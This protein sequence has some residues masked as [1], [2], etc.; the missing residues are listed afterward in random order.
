MRENADAL[1]KEG[2]LKHARVFSVPGSGHHPYIDNPSDTSNF[3]ISSFLEFEEN[4]L[5]N[6]Q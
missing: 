2:T 3:L 6:S 4:A 5:K 1:V